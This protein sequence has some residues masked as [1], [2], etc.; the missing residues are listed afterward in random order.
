M[1]LKLDC[2][3]VHPIYNLFWS[4]DKLLAKIT[5]WIL[6][7]SERYATVCNWLCPS[8]LNI[9]LRINYNEIIEFWKFLWSFC[10]FGSYIT[11]CLIYYYFFYVTSE[12][13]TNNV[14]L[15][16]LIV[17]VKSQLHQYINLNILDL[18]ICY[19][20]VFRKSSGKHI[21]SL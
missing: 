18:N 19:R 16:L 15:W 5:R 7:D 2:N 12:V 21:I 14:L 11:W 1:Q 6:K 17:L 9:I 13:F 8:V 20:A 3:N 4:V 10:S